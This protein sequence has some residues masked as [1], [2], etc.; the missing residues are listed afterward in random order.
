MRKDHTRGIH[1]GSGS[2]SRGPARASSVDRS[3]LPSIAGVLLHFREPPQGGQ[4]PTLA[5][6]H[7][8]VGS[9][10][11]QMRPSAQRQFVY[12]CSKAASGTNVNTDHCKRQPV[13]PAGI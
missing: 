9:T 1:Q 8:P 5:M 13:P 10:S 11:H 7:A 6:R 4:D 3:G 12:F 2:A